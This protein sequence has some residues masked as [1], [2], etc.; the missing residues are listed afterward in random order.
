MPKRSDEHMEG[1]RRQILDGAR[2]AFA[3]HGYEGATVERLEQEIG[4]S[5][6][7]IFHYYAN[8]FELFFA[9]AQEDQQRGAQQ[10]L[11]EGFEPLLR[12][13]ADENPDWIG[14]YLE[15]ARMLRTDPKLRKAWMLR[16]KE[17]DELLLARMQELQAAGA[18]RDDLDAN[19]IGRFLGLV[20]D[21]V[22]L[23]LGA[24]VRVDVEPVIRL[25]ND[26]IAPRK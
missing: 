20:V 12:R 21:G 16:S 23:S 13:I 7:A 2:Q 3:K 26:A 9:L 18:V 5:R 8:K 22:A 14:V 19:E 6:G 11:E 4:L 10:W 24:G 25:V 15:V 17:H 1:R